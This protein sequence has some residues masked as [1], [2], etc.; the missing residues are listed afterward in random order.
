MEQDE[1]TS[2]LFEREYI[3]V[4]PILERILPQLNRD[5][6]L[7]KK[8][9]T[10]GMYEGITAFELSRATCNHYFRTFAAEYETEHPDLKQID[11]DWYAVLRDFIQRWALDPPGRIIEKMYNDV[12]ELLDSENSKDLEDYNQERKNR[13][14]Q[15]LNVPYKPIRMK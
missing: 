12:R 6:W 15:I 11:L 14:L 2:A 13:G 8:L 4:K 3:K 1:I 9:K 5:G 10:G 7:P